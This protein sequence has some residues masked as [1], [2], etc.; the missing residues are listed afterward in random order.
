MYCLMHSPG[1]PSV[2]EVNF[3][4]SI[5]KLHMYTNE[6]RQT[7]EIVPST[8]PISVQCITTVIH[9]SIDCSSNGK[10]TAGSQLH[11]E[12]GVDVGQLYSI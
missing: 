4:I 10:K 12:Q 5:R 9:A 1:N 6:N 7:H 3:S 2:G 11:V 8:Y